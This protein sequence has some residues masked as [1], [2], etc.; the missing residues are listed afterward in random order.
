[1]TPLEYIQRGVIQRGLIQR[2]LI[3]RVVIQRGVI[4]R[5]VIQ[6]GIFQS[7][8]ITS[9]NNLVYRNTSDC[10][11]ISRIISFDISVLGRLAK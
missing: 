9:T 11:A 3:Q 8:V 2:S 7:G 6:S 5:R 4:E 1:M 10:L